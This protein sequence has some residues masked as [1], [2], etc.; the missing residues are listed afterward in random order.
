MPCIKMLDAHM[1]QRHIL[2][3]TLEQ[4]LEQN[5]MT[6]AA[7][8]ARIGCSQSQVHRLRKGK[9]FPSPNM[10][11][12]I[13]AATDGLVKAGDWYAANFAEAI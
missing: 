13:E 10:V 11:R 4:F 9:S 7:F 1:H 6:E 3:M 8:A 5:A 2:G 12:R